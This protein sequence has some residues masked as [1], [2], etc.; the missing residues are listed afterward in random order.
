LRFKVP[1][2]FEEKEKDCILER[3]HLTRNPNP[4]CPIKAL[5]PQSP[6][7]DRVLDRKGSVFL[8]PGLE[9]LVP[10]TNLC[11]LASL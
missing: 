1:W 3:L 7:E 4:L 10:S 11:L 6:L 8:R 2:T 9:E 5:I